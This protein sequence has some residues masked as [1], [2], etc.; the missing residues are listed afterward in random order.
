VKFWL[1]AARLARSAVAGA[2]AAAADLASLAVLVQIV[3][4]EPRVASVPALTIGAAVMFVGQRQL[5]FRVRGGNVA[6]ELLLFTFVQLGGLGL[7]AL[8]YDRLLRWVPSAAQH[9][10]LAR[11]AVTNVVWLGYSFP[12]WHF[13]FRE[14]PPGK[15]APS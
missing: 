11:L 4:L 3:G 1:L 13:V 9:Y 14:K 5:A 10:V 6:R 2:I 12:L 15:P 8:L 7:T